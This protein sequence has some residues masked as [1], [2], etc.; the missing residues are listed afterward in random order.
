MYILKH[1]HH[2]C[3]LLFIE[4]LFECT[5]LKERL[6]DGVLGIH[7]GFSFF[8]VWVL[9]PTIWVCNLKGQ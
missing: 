5:L 3:V 1:V 6:C 8:A 9:H 2:L 4:F 7:E